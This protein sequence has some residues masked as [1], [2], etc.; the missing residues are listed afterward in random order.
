M[1]SKKVKGVNISR[2]VLKVRP[3]TTGEVV[4]LLRDIR[5]L[6]QKDL[7]MHFHITSTA[8][9][10]WESGDRNP[11]KWI[12]KELSKMAREYSRE[13]MA[14]FFQQ[15]AGMAGEVVRKYPL[16]E[17]I[18]YIIPLRPISPGEVI[19]DEIERSCEPLE[20]ETQ[21]DQRSESARSYNKDAPLPE[22]LGPSPLTKQQRKDLR[23]EAHDWID[24]IFE[25][26]AADEIIKRAVAHLRQDGGH[27]RRLRD[28]QKK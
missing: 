22:D 3:K 14:L 19:D 21:A 15:K 24:Q 9:A 2:D 28:A 20:S 27:W 26:P 17:E 4:K 16:Y 18:D 5:H 12:A 25:A 10:L 6:T 1:S 7:A 13:K 8:V 23:I 11:N